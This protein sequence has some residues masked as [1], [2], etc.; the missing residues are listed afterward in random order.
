MAS[1]K[2]IPVVVHGTYHKGWAVI[3]HDGLSRMGRN[4]IHF[5]SGHFTDEA[6][7]SG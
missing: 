3:K 5:A 1:A 2:E 6:V 4:H 7:I